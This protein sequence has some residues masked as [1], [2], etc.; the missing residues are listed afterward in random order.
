MYHKTQTEKD[1][2]PKTKQKEKVPPLGGLLVRRND[3]SHASETQLS[4]RDK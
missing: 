1:P 3:Q 4:L 2:K